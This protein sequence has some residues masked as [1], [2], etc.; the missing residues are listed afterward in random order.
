MSKIAKAIRGLWWMK[1]TMVNSG[2]KRLRNYHY[3]HSFNNCQK[4][5]KCILQKTHPLTVIQHSHLV[6]Q[7]KKKVKR[8]YIKTIL[9]CIIKPFKT[10]QNSKD[11]ITEIMEQSHMKEIRPEI[12]FLYNFALSF[13]RHA[14]ISIYYQFLQHSGPKLCIY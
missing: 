6:S 8:M 3:L 12:D 4:V 10:T 9:L 14:S 13:V 7:T 5:P 11:G 2:L 1:M